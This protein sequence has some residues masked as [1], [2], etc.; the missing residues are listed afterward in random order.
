MSEDQALLPVRMINEYVYCP[1]LFWLEHVEREFASSYDTI[2]GERIHRRVDRPRG[3]LP[4]DLEQFKR[5][6]TSVELTSDKLGIVAKIDIVRPDG[7]F[8]IPVDYKRGRRPIAGVY[9][10]ELV[11]IALQGMLLREH[12]YAVERGR[13][14]Y[15]ESKEYAD[16][17]LDGYLEAKALKAIDGAKAIAARTSIPQPLRDS[18]KC[19]RCSLHAI[20]LPDETNAVRGAQQQAIRPFAAG[21]ADG[22]SI[23]VNEA[24]SR[25]GLKGEVLEIRK[26]DRLVADARLNDV[27]TVSLFG[28]VQISSQAARALLGR[29]VPL[30]YHSY[31]GWLSGVAK[32]ISDHSV[33]LRIAQHRVVAEDSER[34]LSIAR[35]LVEG[36]VRK[37]RTMIRRGLGEQ[38]KPA[39]QAMAFT[40]ASNLACSGSRSASWV[41]GKCRQDL[42]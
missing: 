20:C 14:Y 5:D 1:R 32:S 26:D 6:V 9:D 28:N 37:Q 7:D 25:L 41:R 30:L 2:D 12:G 10:P 27:Q 23:Y 36:K 16:V 31:G 34:A 19:A 17:E 22:V 35:A 15:A 13:I 21:L 8:V 33:D 11:Q 3:E 24:G 40:G 4:V 42:L 39:L 18:P 29:D 38:A